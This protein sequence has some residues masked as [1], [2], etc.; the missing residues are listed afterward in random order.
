MSGNGGLV[1]PGRERRFSSLVHVLPALKPFIAPEALE[2]ERGERFLLRLGAN[3]S[4]WGCA[5]AVQAAAAEV[6]G[7]ATHYCDPEGI[8]LRT[9]IA[10]QLGCSPE[11]I[12][13]GEGIDGLL[14]LMVRLFIDPGYHVVTTDGTYPTLLYHCHGFGAKVVA[15]PYKQRR[16]DLGGLLAAARRSHARLVYL[17]NPDNPSGFVAAPDEVEAL[18][19]SLPPKCVLLLDEAYADFAR[20]G[21]LPSIDCASASVVRLRT[22]SKAHGLAGLRVGF[23]VAPA[24]IGAGLD[25]IRSHFG[26]NL[27]GQRLCEIS[28]GA[29][30]FLAG[31]VSEVEQGRSEYQSLGAQVGLEPLPSRTNFVTFDAGSVKASIAWVS[32]LAAEGVFVRRPSAGE[33]ATCIRITV[34]TAGERALLRPVLQ[35]IASRM[36]RSEHREIEVS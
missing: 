2:R 17:A 25:K 32:A 15:V 16:P 4:A 31:V 12:T 36:A 13:L 3:E 29:R 26:V 10:K 9:G 28:L 19:E 18:A 1:Q 8:Q 30:A 5:P 24:A 7:E 20:P 23:A 6:I 21:E 27:P 14:G 11:N 22:F 33:L 34:G 35:K